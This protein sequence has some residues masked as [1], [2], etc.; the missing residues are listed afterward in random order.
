LPAG[1][2]VLARVRGVEVLGGSLVRGRRGRLV[3]AALLDDLG[4]GPEVPRALLDDSGPLDTNVAV[5]LLTAGNRRLIVV[6]DVDAGGQEAVDMLALVAARLVMCSTAVVA[7]AGGPL[8]MG[9]DLNLR[10]LSD[11]VLSAV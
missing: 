7:T 8:G 5:R 4:A 2:A 3:W 6:D 10:A 1:V 9:R 11:P